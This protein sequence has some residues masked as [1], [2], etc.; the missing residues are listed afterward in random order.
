[1]TALA[2]AIRVF[3]RRH[4]GK[5]FKVTRS[6][7]SS[8][9]ATEYRMGEAVILEQLERRA[10]RQQSSDEEPRLPLEPSDD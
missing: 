4:G 7:G 9:E 1:L 3:L 6:D 5:V 8:V 10:D 2:A